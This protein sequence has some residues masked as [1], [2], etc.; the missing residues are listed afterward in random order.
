MKKVD[1]IDRGK[2]TK[3]IKYILDEYEKDYRKKFNK[4]EFEDQLALIEIINELKE[5]RYVKI[6]KNTFD[7]SLLGIRYLKDIYS[8]HDEIIENIKSQWSSVLLTYSL[9]IISIFIAIYSIPSIEIRIVLIIETVIII[10]LAFI[11][12]NRIQKM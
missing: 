6:G 4:N 11:G 7:I 12:V 10:V 2:K 1:K 8:K 3:L 5:L 9:A